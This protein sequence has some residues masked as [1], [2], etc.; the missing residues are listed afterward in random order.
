[1]RCEWGPRLFT[2]GFTKQFSKRTE[3]LASQ[4]TEEAV[5]YLLGVEEYPPS[6]TWCW[7]P[8]ATISTR[9]L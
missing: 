8:D 2:L 1:M 3:I 5:P 6:I 4:V 7:A 9:F